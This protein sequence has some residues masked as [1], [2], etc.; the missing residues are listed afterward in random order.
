MSFTQLRLSKSINQSRGIF[1]KYIYETDTDTIETVT[2][3]GYFDQSRFIDK[4]RWQDSIIEC[5]CSDGYIVGRISGN[6]IVVL[7]VSDG[8]ITTEL[9]AFSMSDQQPTG[10]DTPLQIEFGEAQGSGS[11]PFQIDAN[12]K[13]TINETRLFNITLTFSLS[14]TTSTGNAIIFIRFLIDGVQD[15]NPIAAIMAD[16]DM[17]I[18]LPFSRVVAFPAGSEITFELIRDSTG[19]DNGGLS[20]FTANTSGWGASPSASLRIN[21]L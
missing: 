18:P 20:S 16:D 13:L 12:G 11:D 17:T 1:D 14:R 10:L 15:G 5:L 9:L 8:D 4:P 3:D 2:S 21:T 7:L 6:G 19:I